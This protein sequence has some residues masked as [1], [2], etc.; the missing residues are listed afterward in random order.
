MNCLGDERGRA[1]VQ[2]SRISDNSASDAEQGGR[3]VV[4][5]LW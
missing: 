1:N 5:N 3:V 2:S 4:H